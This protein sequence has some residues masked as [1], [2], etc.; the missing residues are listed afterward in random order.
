M[1]EYIRVML[2]PKINMRCHKCGRIVG[3]TAP[4]KSGYLVQSGPGKGFFCNRTHAIEASN[5]IIEAYP[6]LKAKS[7]SIFKSIT[8]T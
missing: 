7:E 8:L 6:E 1:K 3:P 2:T 5:E 4:L